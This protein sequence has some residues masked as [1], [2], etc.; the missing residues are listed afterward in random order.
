M[1]NP[2]RIINNFYNIVKIYLV[3]DGSSRKMRSNAHKQE[4]VE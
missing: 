4:V 2:D 3:N 1:F